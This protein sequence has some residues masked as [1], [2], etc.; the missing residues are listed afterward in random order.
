MADYNFQVTSAQRIPHQHQSNQP[1][2]AELALEA[3][4][5]HRRLE[6]AHRLETLHQQHL[7][8][9]EAA[10]EAYLAIQYRASEEVLAERRRLQQQQVERRSFPTLIN[11]YYKD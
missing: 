6:Q 2:Q 5:R 7:D 1:T 9:A 11:H 4:L 8:S 10:L 3:E